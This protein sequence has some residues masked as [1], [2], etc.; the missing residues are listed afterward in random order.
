[1]TE[2]Q[3][4]PWTQDEVEDR[5]KIIYGQ[6]QVDSLVLRAS[7]IQDDDTAHSALIS[8]SLRHANGDSQAIRVRV[9]PVPG[10]SRRPSLVWERD[11]VTKDHGRKSWELIAG[12]LRLRNAIDKAPREDGDVFV[13]GTYEE[14][15]V[16]W[17]RV[18]R[19]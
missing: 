11:H 2:T 4:N 6:T 12:K 9:K 10:H 7:T 19:L 16:S 18:R 8:G 5:K 13:K 14:E 17:T 3:S 15:Q 1:M